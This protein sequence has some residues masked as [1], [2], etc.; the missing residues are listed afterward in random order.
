LTLKCP[1][2][3]RL[4]RRFV[5]RRLNARPVGLCQPTPDVALLQA[6]GYK[7]RLPKLDPYPNVDPETMSPYQHGEVFV[8]DGGFRNTRRERDRG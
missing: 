8:T 2:S 7:V 3:R 4:R 1:T 5:S 6:R